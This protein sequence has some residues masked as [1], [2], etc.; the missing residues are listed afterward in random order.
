VTPSSVEDFA[1][2][3]TG[4]FGEPDQVIKFDDVNVFVFAPR[5]QDKTGFWIYLTG[6]M[7]LKEMEL[8]PAG[9]EAKVPSRA[10][11]VFYSARKDPRYIDML[12]LLVVFPFVDKTFVSMGHTVGLSEAI[13]DSG[14]LNAVVLLK[15]LFRGHAEVFDAVRV[16]GDAVNFL[17]VVPITESERQYKQVH[18]L[19]ALLDVFTDAKNPLVFEGGRDAYV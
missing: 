15:T 12:T 1:T 2:L 7:S 10:E 18:G 9:R 19:D 8:P 14:S 4:W 3:Y 11:Y 13:N 17:W 6:G 16:A 5:E